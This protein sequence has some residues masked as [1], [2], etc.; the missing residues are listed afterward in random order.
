MSDPI[1]VIALPDDRRLGFNIKFNLGDTWY[2]RRPT[3]AIDP[4]EDAIAISNQEPRRRSLRMPS[5]QIPFVAD[6]K[7]DVL[8]NEIDAVSQMNQ[9]GSRRAVKPRIDFNDDW[10]TF[11][12]PEFNARWPPA[13]PESSQTAH[14]NF[15][16]TLMLVISQRGRNGALTTDEMRRRAAVTGANSNDLISHN[17]G[18]ITGALCE[19]FDQ[20]PW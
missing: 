15:G 20:Y 3:A 5:A 2:S 17:V 4:I 12:P 18:P 9:L 8:G 11:R 1:S 10:A 7:L 16:D 13:K 19:F 6:D 14:G